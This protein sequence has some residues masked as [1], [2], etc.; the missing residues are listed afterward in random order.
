MPNYQ[1]AR[2]YALKSNQT[3]NIY[4]G[5]TC[6][7][8]LCQR[9]CQHMV[10]HRR[11]KNGKSKQRCASFKIC[12]YDDM[13]IEL[14]ENYPCDTKEELFQR[15]GELIRETENCVNY[16]IAG[17]T[18]KQYTEDNKEKVEEYQKQYQIDHQ[19]RIKEQKRLNHLKNKESRN[20]LS[21]AY[22]EKNKEAQLAR[23]SVKYTCGCG[24]T[25]TT[26]KKSRHAKSQKHIK[27]LTSLDT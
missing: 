15:E 26:G 17:R 23:Q 10:K 13:Y 3:D 22:Y 20:A 27:Y 4:I 21:K 5:S 2:I 7:K 9:K 6:Q 24:K 16:R 18:K 11:L 19:E 8:Y 1:N 25:L 12:E 14:I